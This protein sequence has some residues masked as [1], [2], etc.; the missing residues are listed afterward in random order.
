MADF[1]AAAWEA[2]PQFGL[3]PRRIDILSQSENVVCDVT[4]S[5]G[6]HL[7]MRLHRPEYNSLA[8]LES[9]VQWVTALRRAGLPVPSA[10]PTL[11]GAHYTAVSVDGQTRHVGLV[12][13]VDGRPLA[14]SAEIDG[15]REQTYT[16]IGQLC[17]RIREHGKSWSPPSDFVRRRW[18]T[19]GFLGEDPHW[20]R[21]W[22][23][24]ALSHE[25]R[26]LFAEVRSQLRAE[27]STL[28]V[29]R[30]HFGLI[31]ADLHRGNL[32]SNGDQLTM[33]DFDDAGFGWFVH[34]IA[35]AL[36]P[37]RDEPWFEDARSALLSGY[38][39]VHPLAQEEASWIDTFLVLRSLTNVSWLD[40]RPELSSPEDFE[41]V[42][43]QAEVAARR[44]LTPGTHR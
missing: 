33:I 10:I 29:D 35:I 27:L 38:R 30:G 20:G 18:D 44:Y 12:E 7:I 17:A 42:S 26:T 31:H 23:V 37:I 6:D 13:W 1:L 4:T 39:T 24:D 28:P 41:H 19:D 11:D 9:E 14:S 5:G 8:E 3:N 15:S 16:R 36:H 25:R 2:A 32:M 22:E 34:D 40:A 21:F 43:A